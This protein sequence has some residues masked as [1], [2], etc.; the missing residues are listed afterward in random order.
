MTEHP[1]VAIRSLLAE[2]V[3][4]G[5]R[6]QIR[7]ADVAIHGAD[8]LPSTLRDALEAHRQ[9]GTLWIYL[10]GEGDEDGPRALLAALGVTPC[11]VETVPEA[12]AAVRQ[13]ILDLRQHGGHLAVD[14]ETAP[15]PEHEIP[16]FV[17]LNS[18]GALSGRRARHDDKTALDP[19]RARPHVLQAYAG[20]RTVFLFRHA[21]LEL[22]AK[23]R[24]LRRQIL[25][26]HN[27][28]FDAKM[29]RAFQPPQAPTPRR[30]GQVHCSMQAS[31]LFL[32]V[33]ERGE[34]RKLKAV[35][36]SLLHLDMPKDLAVSCWSAERLT[37]GQ[38]AYAACDVA[39]TWRIWDIVYPEL[40]QLNRL[41]A[42]RLQRNAVPAVIRMELAGMPLDTA[43]HGRQTERWAREFAEAAHEFQKAAGQSVPTSQNATRAYLQRLLSPEEQDAWPRT[44][45]A[46]LLKVDEDTL[47]TVITRFPTIRPLLVV[48]AKYKLM[49]TFGDGLLKFINPVTHRIHCSFNI[50]SSKAGRFSANDPNLQ[51]LPR[52]K[53]PEFR[54]CIKAESGYVLIGCDLN[55]IEVRAFA[56]RTQDETLT[57]VY[58]AENRDLH[59][60]VAASILGIPVD[61]V[62]PEQRQLAKAIVFG[63]IYGAGPR[64]I[65]QTVYADFGVLWSEED[66]RAALDIFFTT[67]APRGYVWRSRHADLCKQQGILRIGCGRVVEAAWEPSGRISF[68]QACNLP[69]QGIAADCML[70]A[71]KLAH[72]SLTRARVR[73]GLIATV[74]DELLAEVAEADADLTR[75][76]MQQAMIDAFETTFPG[77]PSNGVAKAFI[78]Q[79]WADLK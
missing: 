25:V 76:L 14:T 19:Y 73:G 9:A 48:Q 4:L 67:Y 70:R 11:L 75:E 27:A 24:W 32:G 2:A 59:R 35:T 18:T 13:L 42:Y 7:G 12:R 34:K 64:R 26:F 29:L 30:P 37:A 3:Q 31:G 8:A 51:Q 44:E 5:V 16:V 53:A 47:R 60:E 23:S 22:V 49:Q 39:A 1:F 36:K 74:H 71:I 43:E 50:A 41:E 46:G 63:A 10:G 69:I 68:P 17:D 78:G 54:E 6:F 77:A 62:S 38:I 61:Q 55:N 33:G 65:S 66:A 57:G 79:S 58:A 56:W 52:A 21:A 28:S 72:N 20:G 15:D 45:K 40:R